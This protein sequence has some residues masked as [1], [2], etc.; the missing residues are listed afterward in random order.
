M[1]EEKAGHQVDTN[2]EV[3]CQLQCRVECSDS[4]HTSSFPA[5]AASATSTKHDSI[6]TSTGV[7]TA[8]KPTSVFTCSSAFFKVFLSEFSKANALLSLWMSW[9]LKCGHIP[10]FKG[11]QVTNMAVFSCKSFKMS[12]KWLRYV[13]TV[14]NLH[15]TLKW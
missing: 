9:W 13:G 2:N 7:A 4:S 15:R 14:F 8:F 10:H 3:C 11:Q 12:L 5:S 1:C 6:L